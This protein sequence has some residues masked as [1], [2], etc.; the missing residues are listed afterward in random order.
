MT[1]PLV[2]NNIITQFQKN[3]SSFFSFYLSKFVNKKV[4]FPTYAELFTFSFIPS[5]SRVSEL[6]VAI[7]SIN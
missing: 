4:G 1:T 6:T 5:I 2:F 7:L 3:Y